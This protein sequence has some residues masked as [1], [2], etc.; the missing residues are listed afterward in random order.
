MPVLNKFLIVLS[1]IAVVFVG[2]LGSKQNFNLNKDSIS[3]EQDKALGKVTNPHLIKDSDLD[4]I[5]SLNIED[6]EKGLLIR[7]AYFYQEVIMHSKD[8]EWIIKDHERF[9]YNAFCVSHYF[10]KSSWFEDFWKK[11]TQ[12]SNDTYLA[13]YLNNVIKL[14]LPFPAASALSPDKCLD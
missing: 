12:S 4:Y 14:K 3:L 2:Y 13:E 1:I 5:N 11:I 7:T 8:S 10:Q 9:Y 6:K